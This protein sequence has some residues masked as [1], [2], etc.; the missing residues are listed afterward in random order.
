M[1]NNFPRISPHC[2][3]EE[4]IE[5]LL[6]ATLHYLIDSCVNFSA[7]QKD[8]LSYFIIDNLIGSPPSYP[9]TIFN[10]DGKQSRFFVLERQDIDLIVIQ[11]FCGLLEAL[12]SQKYHGL[13]SCQR[14]TYSIGSI[15]CALVNLCN[16]YRALQHSMGNFYKE[17]PQLRCTELRLKMRL[18]GLHLQLERVVHE[19]NTRFSVSSWA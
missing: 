14:E 2:L 6:L 13:K 5:L 9:A 15:K 16:N 3:E 18:A 1:S 4:M 7:T 19:Q 11:F 8:F 10:N 17:L 12:C